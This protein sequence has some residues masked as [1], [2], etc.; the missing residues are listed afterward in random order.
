MI[1]FEYD[2]DIKYII[3]EMFGRFARAI[4]KMLPL[5]AVL[6]HNFSYKMSTNA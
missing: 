5:S 2:L 1:S 6:M 3:I 4:S